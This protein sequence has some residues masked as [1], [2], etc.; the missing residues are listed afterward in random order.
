LAKDRLKKDLK[1]LLEK[2]ENSNGMSL[3]AK[4]VP[5]ENK[6]WGYQAKRLA[7]ILFP[8]SSTPRK[9]YRVLGPLR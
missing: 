1:I 4:W 2:K 8:E 7:G 6:A 5:R 3:M 9:D